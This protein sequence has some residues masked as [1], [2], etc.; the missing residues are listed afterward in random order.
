MTELEKAR[1]EVE[2][3]RHT[4][5]TLKECAAEERKIWH[6]KHLDRYYC[7]ALDRLDVKR[8]GAEAYLWRLETIGR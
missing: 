3:I 8:T 5:N 1:R 2:L 7:E 4:I 6:D